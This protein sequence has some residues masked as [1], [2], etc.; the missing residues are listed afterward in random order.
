[1]VCALHLSLVSIPFYEIPLY[2]PTIYKIFSLTLIIITP[3]VVGVYR[4]CPGHLA[5]K[6]SSFHF[7]YVDHFASEDIQMKNRQKGNSYL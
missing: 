6:N 3:R 2:P 1:M 5:F 4:D 7:H